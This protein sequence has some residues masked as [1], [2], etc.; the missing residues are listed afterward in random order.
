MLDIFTTNQ[1]SSS[2][3]IIIG[4]IAVIILAIIAYFIWAYFE[5]WWPFK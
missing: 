4:S 1:N 2:S 5:K 3:L